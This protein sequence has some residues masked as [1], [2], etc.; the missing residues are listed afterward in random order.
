MLRFLTHCHAGRNAVRNPLPLAGKLR[1][2][3][4]R[5][6]LLGHD[7]LQ[8]PQE[9][10]RLIRR[11]QAVVSEDGSCGIILGVN[12]TCQNSLEGNCCS[13]R[14][15]CGSTAPF[16]GNGCQPA[17]GTCG[18]PKI[19]TDGPCGGSSGLTCRGSELGNCCSR[20]GFCGSDPIYC[21]LGCQP[22][23]GICPQ[24]QPQSQSTSTPALLS[25][26]PSST[27]QSPTRSPGLND[28][29]QAKADPTGGM[30]M[31]VG[32]GVG[33]GAIV[34]AIG[35]LTWWLLVLRKR[36]KQQAQ[37]RTLE[38]EKTVTEDDKQQVGPYEVGDGSV[39]AELPGAEGVYELPSKAWT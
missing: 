11:Q 7:E 29:S 20:Q 30:A 24:A 16:C 1:L 38:L 36:R 21:G 14:G 33:I 26:T 9:P 23:F 25:A 4:P 27:I 17:F 19:S 2:T 37:S 22:A 31:K 3:L 18:D 8:R 6:R 5:P 13:R 28:K 39:R 15:F 35:G 12:T 32:L 10:F 34:L